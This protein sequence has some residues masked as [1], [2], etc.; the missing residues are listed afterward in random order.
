MLVVVHVVPPLAHVHPEP[1][2]DTSDRPVGTASVMVTV[3]L[4]GL[5]PDA[6][7]TVTLYVAPVC[8]CVKL[9][10]CVF[11]MLNIRLSTAVKFAVTDREALI[12]TDCWLAVPL[13][14]P[15]QLVN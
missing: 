5:A 10:V 7:D 4:V 6:F 2:I 11:A 14:S 1:A 12:V 9:P 8:P 3:P 15:D 13:T